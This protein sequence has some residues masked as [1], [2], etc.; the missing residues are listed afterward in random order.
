MKASAIFAQVLR[1]LTLVAAFTAAGV[2][3]TSLAQEAFRNDQTGSAVSGNGGNWGGWTTATYCPPGSWASG[4][5]MRVEPSVGSGDDT[6]LNAVALYC[7]DRAG[8]RVARISPHPGFWGDWREGANCTQ[9]AH[10]THFIL[11]VEPSQ[12]SGDDT[13]ANSVAFWCNNQQRLEAQG[14]QWGTYGEWRGGFSNS[15]ICGLR[16]KVEDRQGTGDDTALND[17]EFFWCTIR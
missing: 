13:A 16:A 1:N 6:A 3:S 4:Y 15:A 17:L 14:G 11:K 9:G 7:S 5:A 2:P 12:G 10:F 8:Q